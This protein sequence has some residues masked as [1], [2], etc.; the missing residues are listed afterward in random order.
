[1]NYSCP[2]PECTFN[3][4]GVSFSELEAREVAHHCPVCKRPLSSN[5]PDHEVSGFMEEIR[6]DA[7]AMFGREDELDEILSSV[8]ENRE[9]VLWIAGQAGIGKSFL[10]AKLT[11][12]LIDQ[13]IENEPLVLAYR[14]RAEDRERCNRESFARFVVERLEEAKLIE[15][16]SAGETEE[17]SW[18]GHQ[19]ACLNAQSRV[20]LILDGLDEI[21]QRD[22]NFA[23]EVPLAHQYPN[24]LWVC[25][26]KPTL[27]L[28]R[29]MK[30]AISLFPEGLP[31]MRDL[32]LK[33]M[34][35]SSIAPLWKDLNLPTGKKGERLVERFVEDATRR[36]SGLPLFAKHVL[37][38]LKSGKYELGKGTLPELPAGLDAYHEDLLGRLGTGDLQAMTTQL[39]ATLTVAHEPLALRELIAFLSFRKLITG[40]KASGVVEESLKALSSM[41]NTAPDPEEEVGYQFFH[42]TLR[43]HALEASGLS[44][45]VELARDAF[46]DLVTE[47]DPPEVLSNYLTRCSVRHL[48]QAGRNE[49]A[50]DF[51]LDLENLHAMNVLGIEWP[52]LLGYWEELGGEREAMKYLDSIT[53]VFE[54]E[55]E[56]QDLKKI[57]LVCLLA[58]EA[59]WNK[60]ERAI[61]EQA[62]RLHLRIL[63]PKHPRVALCWRNLAHTEG[64]ER[65]KEYKAMAKWAELRAQGQFA[66]NVDPEAFEKEVGIPYSRALEIEEELK[67]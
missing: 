7:E 18:L 37:E 33:V 51:L 40:K 17:R 8:K 64:K 36:A 47:G 6:R 19:L 54:N 14:F 27:E 32:D 66:E 23:E 9:G 62:L 53:Q 61:C 58:R 50:R 35:A 20:I 11:T 12:T 21:A 60:C 10:L 5:R 49:Q 65:A 26:G 48:M 16:D 4:S 1:M 67:G 44:N 45:S 63:G 57:D 52:E 59:N 30:P 39:V 38:D 15:E 2:T 55:P 34:L 31:L 13:P 46:A 56:E 43:D 29:T 28:E 42:P 41:I 25:A 24:L 3:L 22:E